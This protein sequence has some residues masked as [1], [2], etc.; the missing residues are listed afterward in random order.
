MLAY[1]GVRLRGR[2]SYLVRPRRCMLPHMSH[3]NMPVAS[4]GADTS[5]ISST[6]HA[7]MEVDGS[8]IPAPF[9][10]TGGAPEAASGRANG[11]GI[12]SSAGA[13]IHDAATQQGS[14]IP[15]PAHE[16][17]ISM[18][19][20]LSMTMD[21]SILNMS[22]PVIDASVP[23]ISF[24]PGLP[25]PG[26]QPD[27][28][29]LREELEAQ[30]AQF[31]ALSEHSHAKFVVDRSWYQSELRAG[32]GRAE[33]VRNHAELRE[34]GLRLAEAGWN[35]ELQGMMEMLR[36]RD[37]AT[38]EQARRMQSELESRMQSELESQSVMLKNELDLSR[39]QTAAV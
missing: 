9:G 29:L 3:R 26:H 6:Q 4:Q 16:G 35:S 21:D 15:H 1:Q 28:T 20:I 38:Q 12:S 37:E 30:R 7:T 11:R 27:V 18:D 19:L 33:N 22:A 23:S 39:R 2:P 8:T 17:E 13:G 36:F 25:V 14:G 10:C 31:G 32:E 5:G 24:P 34:T